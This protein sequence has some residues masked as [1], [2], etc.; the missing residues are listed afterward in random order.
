MRYVLSFPSGERFADSSIKFGLAPSSLLNAIVAL[1]PHVA[2]FRFR[3]LRLWQIRYQISEWLYTQDTY[4]LLEGA[5]GPRDPWRP[6]KDACAAAGNTLE[7][8]ECKIMAVAPEFLDLR[9]RGIQLETTAAPHPAT[10]GDYPSAREP[11][12]VAAAPAVLGRLAGPEG[13]FWYPEGSQPNDF[14]VC[15][16]QLVVKPEKVR[17]ARERP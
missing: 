5:T 15:P 14:G 6:T 7:L 9:F 4:F 17:M 16:P 2:L 12:W 1:C 8:V 13:I 10:L 3:V 11:P